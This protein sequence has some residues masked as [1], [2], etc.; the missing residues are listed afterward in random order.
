MIQQTKSL[1]RLHHERYPLARPRDFYKL[2]YQGVYGVGHMISE[3][4]MD[5]LHEEA[6]RVDLSEYPGRTLLEP[7][8]WNGKMVRV[9]LRPFMRGRLSLDIL[10]EVMMRSSKRVGKDDDFVRSWNVYLEIAK[11]ELT[12][13][14]NEVDEIQ[15]I[16]DEKGII[17][18]HH[19]E[20]YRKAYYP[21]YRVVWKPFLDEDFDL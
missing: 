2:L 13:T 16:I 5:I 12:S 14:D 6:H 8:S 19:T 10:F 1:I 17:P 18:M 4:A 7:V 9:Y 21:A 20:P 11:T 3:R 15:R